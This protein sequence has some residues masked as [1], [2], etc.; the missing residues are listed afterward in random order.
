MCV[1]VKVAEVVVVAW[2]VGRTVLTEAD[3]RMFKGLQPNSQEHSR[4][5]EDVKAINKY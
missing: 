5:S 3:Q 4:V 1:Q 2:F